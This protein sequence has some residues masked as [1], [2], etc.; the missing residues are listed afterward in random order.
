MRFEPARSME[1]T[2]QGTHDAPIG[3][4]PVCPRARWAPQ[5]TPGDVCEKASEQSFLKQQLLQPSLASWRR[6]SLPRVAL[7]VEAAEA[8]ARR[9]V[10][11]SVLKVSS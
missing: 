8:A 6:G 5:Q 4:Q 1:H 9:S 7:P 11:I 10:S 3:Q 2:A